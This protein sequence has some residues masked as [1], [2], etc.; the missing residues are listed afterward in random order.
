MP[1]GQLPGR[2]RF[3]LLVNFKNM[4]DNSIMFFGV[5]KGKKL[6]NVPAQYLLWLHKE[7]K[8]FGELKKYIENNIDGLKQETLRNG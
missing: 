5:H 4:D 7:N 1:N 6:A 8:C 2:Q 3:F